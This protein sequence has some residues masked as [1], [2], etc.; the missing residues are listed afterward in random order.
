MGMGRDGEPEE[1]RARLRLGPR[2]LEVRR[3]PS[4]SGSGFVGFAELYLDG[5]YEGYLGIPKKGGPDVMIYGRSQIPG[6][7]APGVEPG[8]GDEEIPRDLAVG[9]PSSLASQAASLSMRRPS[10]MDRVKG[11]PR[12]L[13]CLARRQQGEP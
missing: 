1:D 13:R 4:F 8:T 2:T 6:R 11:M 3:A 7:K 9:Q 12:Y 10:I 5:R